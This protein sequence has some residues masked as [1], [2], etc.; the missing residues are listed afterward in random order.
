MPSTE[1]KNYFITV[2]QEDLDLCSSLEYYTHLQIH[3]H[4]CP[5]SVNHKMHPVYSP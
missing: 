1:N 2:K 5:V 3:K 4:F